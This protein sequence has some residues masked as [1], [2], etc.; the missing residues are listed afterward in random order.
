MALIKD[1]A[2]IEDP[3]VTVGPGEAIPARGPLIVGLDQ[4]RE[5]RARLIEREEPIGIRL[6][7]DQHPELIADDLRYFSVVALEFPAFRDG[8]AY[9]YARLLR[10][11]YGFARELRA[12]GDVLVDQLCF[13]LRTGFNAFEI[14]ASDPLAALRSAAAAYSVRYQPTGDGRPTAAELRHGEG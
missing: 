3:F 14:E 10:E 1:N 4:W 5:G 2:V 12:V 9:S 11:H 8:R 7:S 6:K 13:M